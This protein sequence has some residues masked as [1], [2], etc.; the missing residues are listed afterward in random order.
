ME[1][2]LKYRVE[3][4]EE[5]KVLRTFEVQG[6]SRNNMQLVFKGP[7]LPPTTGFGGFEVSLQEEWDGEKVI[8]FDHD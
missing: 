6:T 8:Q 4:M 2:D 3:V 5:E 1:R 7:L